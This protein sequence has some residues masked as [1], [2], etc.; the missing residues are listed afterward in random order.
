MRPHYK[1][2][3]NKRVLKITEPPECRCDGGNHTVENL[4][5]GCS[6]LQRERKKLIRKVSKQ[7]NWPVEKSDLFNKQ[8]I[9]F[10]LQTQWISRNYEHN[11]IIVSCTKIR[12]EHSINNT[13]V[14]RYTGQ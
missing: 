13:S 8:N 3:N 10:N 5:Y 2:I 7:E 14:L 1:T 12:K 4:L 6:K 11:E 9:S